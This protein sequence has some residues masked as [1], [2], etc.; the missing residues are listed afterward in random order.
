MSGQQTQTQY[1][2]NQAIL[3]TAQIHDTIL[4]NETPL[5][6]IINDG[7]YD[8]LV[9]TTTLTSTLNELIL[10]IGDPDVLVMLNTALIQTDQI[11]GAT[12]RNEPH[13]VAQISA[14]LSLNIDTINRLVLFPPSTS[15]TTISPDTMAA[16]AEATAPEI[17]PETLSN[18]GMVRDPEEPVEEKPPESKV[19]EEAPAK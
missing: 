1:L 11:Q 17:N 19:A 7:P 16:A 12:V 2:L 10:M 14:D 13:D 15:T 3:Y 9:V 5:T 18:P 4:I 8:M 6:D